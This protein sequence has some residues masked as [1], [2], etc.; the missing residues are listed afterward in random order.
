MIFTSK[1]RLTLSPSIDQKGIVRWKFAPKNIHQI[2]RVIVKF[3]LLYP[4][5]RNFALQFELSN[6]F[7]KTSN[8]RY[9]HLILTER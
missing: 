8:K 9:N 4:Q 7:I 3:L 1:A 6:L 5:L 2:C